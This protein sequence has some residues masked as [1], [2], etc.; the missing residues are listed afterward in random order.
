MI[1]VNVPSVSGIVIFSNTNSSKIFAVIS[2]ATKYLSLTIGYIMIKKRN[3]KQTIALTKIKHEIIEKDLELKIVKHEKSKAEQDMHT[4]QKVYEK[5]YKEIQINFLE[6]LKI[7]KSLLFLDPK[8]RPSAIIIS[9][10]NTIKDKFSLKEFVATTNVLYPGFT[11]KLKA[12]YPNTNLSEKEISVCCLIVCGFSN[13]ELALFIYQ[14]KDT[15]AI[16]KMKNRLRKKMDIPAYYDV[17]EY[18]LDK[19]VRE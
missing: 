16:E 6:K 18:L 7:I 9:E 14:K 8:R 5:Q 4:F 19:I 10:L 1:S 2:S 17:K 3:I 12:N 11:D 15:Q 13:K